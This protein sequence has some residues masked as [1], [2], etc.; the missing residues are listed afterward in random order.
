MNN[1]HNDLHARVAELESRVRELKSEN[2]FL[3]LHPAFAQG[4]KGERFVCKLTGA[5]ATTLNAPH[6]A[7]LS[8]EVK[9]EIKFSQLNTPN[10]RA[11]ETKRWT[12]NKPM[13]WLDKGKDYDYLVLVGEKDHRF[14]DQYID[15]SPYVAFAIPSAV[16]PG[17]CS[18]GRSVGS[19][20]NLTTNFASLRSEASRT[21][22]R[23]MAPAAMLAVALAS[24]QPQE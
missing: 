1:P 22:V 10:P 18:S 2:E 21:I 6:D 4:L 14:P 13:G 20:V 17:I 15:Q 19:N 7:L 23:H 3:R 9:I 16:V 11:P 12:W 24:G 8:G 5:V